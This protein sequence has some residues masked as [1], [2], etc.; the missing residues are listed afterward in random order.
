MEIDQENRALNKPLL[1][2]RKGTFLPNLSTMDFHVYVLHSTATDRIYVGY[3]S[4]LNARLKTHNELGAKG[5][6]I[7]FRPWTLVHSEIFPTKRMAMNREKE[8]KTARG[9]EFIR[10]HILNRQ[11][12]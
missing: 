2:I 1:E 4:D 10:T 6:T 5:W 7:A 8:L 12:T 3:T 9:R 11:A